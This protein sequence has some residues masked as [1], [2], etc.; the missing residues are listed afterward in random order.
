MV[1]TLA[2]FLICF[3]FTGPPLNQI[4]YLLRPFIASGALN[5]LRSIIAGYLRGSL[6]RGAI[7]LVADLSVWNESLFSCLVLG[8]QRHFGVLLILSASARSLRRP[9]GML[10]S[11]VVFLHVVLQE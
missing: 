1:S 5:L 6:L 10:E 2:Q 9:R 3:V 7:L 4:H 8:A 11:L